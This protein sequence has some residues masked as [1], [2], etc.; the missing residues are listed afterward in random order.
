LRRELPFQP[1][2]LERGRSWTWRFALDRPPD[3]R[4]P[5]WL[6]LRCDTDAA[7][8]AG[9]Q[10]R[11]SLLATGNQARVD[12]VID[13]FSAREFE[14]RLPAAAFAGQ[15]NLEL[16]MTH[17]GEEGSGPLLLQPRQGLT[18]LAPRSGLAVNMARA[19]ALQLSILALL[20][21]LGLTMGMLFSLP[22]AAFCATGLL[23]ATMISAFV[24]NDPA[25][26]E[27][28]PPAEGGSRAVLLSL[29]LSAT[30]AL[31]AAA[32]PALQPAP[33]RH[34]VAA[35]LVPA[36]DLWR[37]WLCNG[38]LLPL[39]CGAAAS[40]ALTRRELPH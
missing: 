22:V 9:M 15:R 25:A 36:S 13:D 28:P 40:A 24:A 26:E 20:A 3:P 34:L 17:A 16:R 23:L 4:H 21:A 33:L 8:R 27:S 14:L 2:A 39:V 11:C 18:L 19:A 30:R 35:E 5:L 32:R 38:L 29:S 37:S 1:A 31:S 6:R 12:F 7:T 10:A